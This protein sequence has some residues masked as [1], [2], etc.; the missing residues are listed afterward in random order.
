MTQRPASDAAA[1][2]FAGSTVR[3][4]HR[5]H[6]LGVDVWSGESEAGLERLTE[7]REMVP[8]AG[9]LAL[10]GSRRDRNGHRGSVSGR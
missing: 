7:P 10:D 3:G 2:R 9:L 4:Q 8:T 6:S 1:A 5:A